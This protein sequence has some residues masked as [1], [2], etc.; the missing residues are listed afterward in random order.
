MFLTALPLMFALTL[1]MR[2]VVGDG[3]VRVRYLRKWLTFTATGAPPRERQLR[4]AG[5]PNVLELEGPKGVRSVVLWP[6]SIEDQFAL[7][8]E[9][10]HSLGN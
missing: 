2:V 10:R 9:C 1:R 3:V 7:V 8:R 6:F 4:I 5:N